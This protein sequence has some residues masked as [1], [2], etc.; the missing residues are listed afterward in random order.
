MPVGIEK[1]KEE[2]QKLQENPYVYRKI[3]VL[4]YPENKYIKDVLS[5][6][7]TLLPNI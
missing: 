6:Y 3:E 7:A 2:R 1:W 5:G 4:R